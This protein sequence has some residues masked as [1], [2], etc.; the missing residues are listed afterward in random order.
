LSSECLCLSRHNS[1]SG[2]RPTWPSCASVCPCFLKATL[3]R[4]TPFSLSTKSTG[5]DLRALS[6]GPR[7]PLCT[8]LVS[9]KFLGA[10]CFRD[11]AYS[12]TCSACLSFPLLERYRR[13]EAYLKSG[14]AAFSDG[15]VDFQQEAYLSQHLASLQISDLQ[16]SSQVVFPKQPKPQLRL[17]ACVPPR[18]PPFPPARTVLLLIHISSEHLCH[19]PC[20]KLTRWSRPQKTSFSSG[21]AVC[22][23][24]AG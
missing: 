2:A 21:C 18:S 11:L 24:M 7:P 10:C 17:R 23:C 9:L 5:A 4:A 8:S 3:S 12:L 13:T 20:C 19:H 15:P 14:F 6:R 22:A 1:F 16:L